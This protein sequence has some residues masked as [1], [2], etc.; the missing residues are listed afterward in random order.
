MD[1][2]L[3][4]FTS[5]RRDLGP[6]RGRLPSLGQDHAAGHRGYVS[7][8][9]EDGVAWLHTKPFSA[10]P[11]H[12]LARCLHSFAHIVEALN[13]APDSEILDV[14]CG[15]GWLSEWLARCGYRVTGIDISEEMVGIARERIARAA[16][17]SP[18]G[19]PVPRAE[20][21]A[22]E[23]TDLSWRGRF[24]AA[25]LYDALH[26]F[27]DERGTLARIRDA[28]APGGRVYVHEGVRPPPGSEG[29]RELIE[30]MRRFGTLESPFDPEYLLSVVREAGFVEV[31]RLMES[32]ALLDL[33]DPRGAVAALRRRLRHPE[34]NTLVAM[35]PV[36][37]AGGA[38]LRARIEL[39]EPPRPAE[40]GRIALRIRVRNEGDVHLPA[41]LGYP[42]PH[43]T[44]TLAPY[45]PRSRARRE[46]ERVP[47]PRSLAP[48]DQVEATVV[49]ALAA[50]DGADEVAIDLVRE[51]IAWL[52]D[53][54]SRPLVVR[55][56]GR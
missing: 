27:H 40:D 3:R 28:L 11:N 44:V 31:R 2:G 48:G 53:L 47:L 20:F 33:G 56:D 14:G 36:A 37:G 46:L 52:G 9:P 10:P 15:P 50:L 26:H 18:A 24:D 21:H 29:E 16:A 25:V 38:A 39:A 22:M 51:G 42:F 12:E 32:D 13:L 23:V 4:R 55:L 19:A 41:A 54:G 5:R 45:V 8:L 7:A 6:Q 17:A 49:L 34:T 35:N 30:E 1:R 43:G